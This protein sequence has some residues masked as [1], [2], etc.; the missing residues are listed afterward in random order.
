VNSGFYTNTIIHRHQ[1]GFVMQGGGYAAPL[2]ANQTPVHK[3]TNASIELEVK[4]SNVLATVGMARTS[5]LNSATSEFFINL[6]DN[7]DLDTRA[8]GYAAFGYIKDFTT[9]NA[10]AQA[11]CVPSVVTGGVG[12]TLYGCLPVPNLII[13]SAVQTR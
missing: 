4:V 7:S 8:G 3:T 13:T 11:P 10:M 6:D 2:A 5:E 12:T 9:V 1:A